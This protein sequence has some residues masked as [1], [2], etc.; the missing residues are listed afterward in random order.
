MKKR[1]VALLLALLMVCSC[2]VASAATYYRLKTTVR[3]WKEPDYDSR[4]LDSY[5]TD[6]AFTITKKVNSKRIVGIT[7][8]NFHSIAF[9][10]ES[11]M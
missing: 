2:A 9:D 10:S 11:S 4:V 3:L 6:W 7:R 1:I 5:R 8:E